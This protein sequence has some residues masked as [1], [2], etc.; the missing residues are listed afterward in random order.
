MHLYIALKFSRLS[1]IMFATL[2]SIVVLR[3]HVYM[4]LYDNSRSRARFFF[5]IYY[6][7]LV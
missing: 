1:M 5:S 2:D 7:R 6:H 3:C 4:L